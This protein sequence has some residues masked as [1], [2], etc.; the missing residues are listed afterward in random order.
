MP[1]N[2]FVNSTLPPFLSITS[3]VNE[4]SADPKNSADIDEMIEMV[5]KLIKLNKTPLSN[6]SP[7]FSTLR[8]YN[9]R[10]ALHGHQEKIACYRAQLVTIIRK[11]TVNKD[12]YQILLK[13]ID[14]Y[15]N[16]PFCLPP[17][18]NIPTSF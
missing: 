10:I 1:T 5:V 12:L 8:D 15:A 7:Y 2:G 14:K 6:K 16:I 3:F 11:S 13:E 17:L 18:T 9:I 4:R